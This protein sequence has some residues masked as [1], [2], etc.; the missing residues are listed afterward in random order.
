MAN[1]SQF[2]KSKTVRIGI[3]EVLAGIIAYTQGQVA[4]GSSFTLEGIITVIMRTITSV[5]LSEK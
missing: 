2:L 1:L 4:V 5:S 3:L